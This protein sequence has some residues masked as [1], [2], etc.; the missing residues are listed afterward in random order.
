MRECQCSH[1]AV[2][3]SQ[4]APLCALL[5]RRPKPGCVTPAS[6]VSTI[7]PVLIISAFVVAW[8][9]FSFLTVGF[10]HPLSEWLP[11]LILSVWCYF[12]TVKITQSSMPG[13]FASL[14]LRSYVGL[15]LWLLAIVLLFPQIDVFKV[16]PSVL[17]GVLYDAVL[18]LFGFGLLHSVSVPSM[19]E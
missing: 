17:G 3:G 14:S 5:D 7:L 13:Q 10:F 18:L 16:A 1:I 8:F 4:I 12:D 6:P 15:G 2:I 11:S 19:A 9:W